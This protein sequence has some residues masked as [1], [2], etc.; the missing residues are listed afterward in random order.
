MNKKYYN[1]YL[2]NAAKDYKSLETYFDDSCS[3]KEVATGT[4]KCIEQECRKIGFKSYYKRVM[5]DTNR[6][7]TIID[8]GSHISFYIIEPMISFEAFRSEEDK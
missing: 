5:N 8:Y 7:A 4:I 2:Y 6:N 1:V 3:E